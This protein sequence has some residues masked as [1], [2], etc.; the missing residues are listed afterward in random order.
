MISYLTSAM[1][2]AGYNSWKDFAGRIS[3]LAIMGKIQ[4]NI[5]TKVRPVDLISIEK[6]KKGT[7]YVSNRVSAG[8]Q[9]GDTAN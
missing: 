9:I 5:Q 2:F 7:L 8:A 6:E 1:G 4:K 3:N